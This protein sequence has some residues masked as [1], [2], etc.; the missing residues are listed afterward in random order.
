MW[1]HTVYACLLT[2]LPSHAISSSAQWWLLSLVIRQNGAQLKYQWVINA[3]VYFVLCCLACPVYPSSSGGSNRRPPR[4]KRKPNLWRG[5]AQKP[6]NTQRQMRDVVWQRR[7]GDNVKQIPLFYLSIFWI[8]TYAC[9]LST[10]CH[11]SM[12]LRAC[13]CGSLTNTRL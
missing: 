10:V 6:S 8:L 9:E 12:C 2:P 1:H 4:D 11:L 3:T 5:K 13:V 7:T